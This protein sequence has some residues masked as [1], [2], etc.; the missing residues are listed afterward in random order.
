MSTRITGGSERGR[1]LRSTKGTGLRPTSESVRAAIFS[2]IGRDAVEGARVLDL[3]AGTGALGIE[4]LSRGASWSDFV[5]VDPRRCQEIR[6]SLRQMGLTDRGHVYRARVEKPWHRLGDGYDLVLV[7]PPYDLDPW[8]ILMARLDGD[9]ILKQGALVVA[10][11]HH[12]RQLAGRYGRLVQIK[13]R[14]HGDTS[15]SIYRAGAIDALRH[16]PRQL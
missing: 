7:D 3:Y 14:R 4:A 12:K 5:E 9:Q 6:E 13:H 15:M 8:E 16:L 11:H 2:I 10:E 1:R